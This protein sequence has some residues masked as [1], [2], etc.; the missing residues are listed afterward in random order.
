MNIVHEF[1]SH[2]PEINNMEG[3]ENHAFAR[4]FEEEI[5]KNLPIIDDGIITIFYSKNI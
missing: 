4:S 2:D 3:E 5:G 1:E